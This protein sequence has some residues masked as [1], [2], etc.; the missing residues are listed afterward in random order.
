MATD[1]IVIDHNIMGGV[2]CI[3]GTR[4]PAAT[5]LGYMA[6][7]ATTAEVLD[8]YPQL[9]IADVL[10]CLQFAAEAVDERHLPLQLPA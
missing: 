9:V 4:I 2:P 10:A 3:R 7:G 8:Y 1:R 5:I 6:E